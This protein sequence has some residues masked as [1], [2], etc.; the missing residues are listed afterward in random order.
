MSWASGSSCIPACRACG[1]QQKSSDGKQ[2]K[3]QLL[4]LVVTRAYAAF[5]RSSWDNSG[6]SLHTHSAAE[7]EMCVFFF[8]TTS[9][10]WFARGRARDQ[11]HW[12]AGLVFLGHNST[13][14]MTPFWLLQKSQQNL[15]ITE[16]EQQSHTATRLLLPALPKVTSK[17][18]KFLND[19]ALNAYCTKIF[20]R[21]ECHN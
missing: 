1:R 6:C 20:G 5:A 16:C 12:W 7:R 15:F 14:P 13:K 21:K 2:R 10:T 9:D 11:Q 19:N 8:P 17:K 18:K 4:G 3:L